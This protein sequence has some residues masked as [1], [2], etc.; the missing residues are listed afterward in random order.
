M[1]WPAN[2]TP[3]WP[4]SS[5]GIEPDVLAVDVELRDHAIELRDRRHARDHRHLAGAHEHRAALD[6]LRRRQ[7]EQQA[8]LVALVGVPVLQHD[9][10]RVRLVAGPAERQVDRADV[11]RDER[12]QLRRL[13]GVG[14]RAGDDAIGLRLDRAA[15]AACGTAAREEPLGDRLEHLLPARLE[16]VDEARQHG[17]VRRASRS[18]DG[19]P[20]GS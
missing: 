1:S 4:C 11:V 10:G 14:L 20:A 9:L 12:E 6:A 16:A 3:Y 2:A 5:V 8:D 17:G 13:L 7:R 19:G 15:A 18:R